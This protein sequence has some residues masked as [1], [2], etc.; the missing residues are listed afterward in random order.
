MLGKEISL[1]DPAGQ[2]TT[3]V[4]LLVVAHFPMHALALCLDALRI[5]NRE[6]QQRLFDWQV[7]SE[8]GD[9][10]P[11][12]CGL[13][14]IP[15]CSIDDAIRSAVVIVIAGY[16]PENACTA[17]LLRWLKRA[18]RAGTLT[19]CVDTGALIL[20]RAGIRIAAET[21]VH[22]E[23]LEG[24]REN[25]RHTPFSARRVAVDESRISSAG[26]IATLDMMLA[27]IENR[28]G[29]ALAYR[30]AQ[31]LN[32]ETYD[33]PAFEGVADPPSY[34]TLPPALAQCLTLIDSHLE[35]PLDL[36]T[37]CT[38]TGLR[39]WTLRRLFIR[40]LGQPPGAWY[41]DRRLDR[42]AT[43]LRYSHL[44]IGEIATATGFSGAAAFSHAFKRRFGR[45]PSRARDHDSG[46]PNR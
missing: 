37:L 11:A 14:V 1:P 32:Y 6:A 46:L 43:L 13:S 39:E 3:T 5:A 25:Y 17:A 8:C 4:T 24:A 22:A 26:G 42:A 44:S 27:L 2:A 29:A 33:R 18:A 31:V 9:P 45:P 7:V 23:A 35:D 40:T 28:H 30:V 36:D 20:A 41:R 16:E 38:A 10:V 12:S 19:G 21:S 15:N 34:S